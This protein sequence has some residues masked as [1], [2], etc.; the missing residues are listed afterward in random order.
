MET[1]TGIETAYGVITGRDGIYLDSML[2]PNEATLIL[3]GQFFTSLGFKA[4]EITFFDIIYLLSIELDFDERVCMESFGYAE[5]SIVIEKFRKMDHSDKIETN[6]LH[7]YFR[8]YD[9]VFEI[10]A[11]GYELKT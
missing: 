10:I 6:H 3:K 11:Q 4:Y 8:T 1:I 5:N 7:Y 2:H 9:T